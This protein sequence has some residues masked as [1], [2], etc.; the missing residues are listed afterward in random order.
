MENSHRN[1]FDVSDLF[2]IL[3]MQKVPTDAF[4]SSD[5]RELHT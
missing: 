5:I 4:C 1:F 3:L 2:I